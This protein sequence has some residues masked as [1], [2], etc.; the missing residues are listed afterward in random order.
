MEKRI[1]ERGDVMDNYLRQILK[2]SE[3]LADTVRL[4]T[5]V[6]KSV[7]AVRLYELYIKLYTVGVP[8]HKGSE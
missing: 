6:T 3:E 5:T 1:M 7:R 2:E 4:L 8:E